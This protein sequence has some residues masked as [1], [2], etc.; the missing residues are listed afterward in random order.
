MVVEM[1]MIRWMCGFTRESRSCSSRDK[2][3]EI[4]H[5][6]FEH[7]KRRGV[8]E[9]VRRCEMIN[10]IQCRRGRWRP[11]MS[12]SEVIRGDLKCIGL[13]EDMAQDRKLWR[14]KIRTVV[15]R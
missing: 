3:R 10:L 11:K 8:N 7:V 9:Q 14:A 2:L 1:R 12:W 6:W 13:T 15:C 4:R 5:R